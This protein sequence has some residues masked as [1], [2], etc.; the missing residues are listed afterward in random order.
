[1]KSTSGHY[2][3]GLDHIRA[4]A[5]FM[6]FAWHFIH[7]ANGFPVPLEGAPYFMPLALI[8]EGHTGVA[9]FMVLSGYLFAKM[10]DGQQIHYGAFFW[11]RFLRLAPLLFLAFLI[12]GA[13]HALNHDPL[14]AYVGTLIYGFVLP[15]WPNGGWSIA[16]EMHFYVALPAIL[17]LSKRWAM[18]PL[19]AIQLMIALRFAIFLIHGE[20]QD[21]AYWTIIGRAD[22]F[23]MGIT[24]FNFRGHLKGQHWLAIGVVA[25]FVVL[26]WTFDSLGGFYQVGKTSAVWIILPTV[27]A[28]A[29][30]TIVA[31]Y[32]TTFSP[33]PVGAS[34][35]L[36]KVGTYSF[37][38][39]LLHFFFVFRMAAYI[40][41]HI[42][43]IANFY[44]AFAWSIVGFA[45]M[46]P[47]AF[48]SYNYFERPFLRLRRSYVA[49]VQKAAAITTTA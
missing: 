14:P 32:D 4:V 22:D 6:V 40:H 5:A 27:E 19:V 2:Y 42:M 48:L 28:L 18:A 49:N 36:S 20:V 34:L 33:K 23:L 38:I 21:A 12:T 29:Y 47:I 25:L 9:L 37:S 17:A 10:I 13:L 15:T 41:R 24:A 45:I 35:I 46:V 30:S 44:L 3:I 43:D 39:Y 16:V 11:N 8:D 1:M 31:Y 26:F 7:G